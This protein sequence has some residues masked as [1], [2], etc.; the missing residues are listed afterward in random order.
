[1]NAQS[2]DLDA[3]CERLGRHRQRATYAAVADLLGLDR[4]SM[5]IGKPFTPRNS[6]VV[7]KGNGMPSKY[8]ESQVHPELFSN[9]FVISTTVDLREWLGGHP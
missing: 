1:M 6:W 9:P 8:E 7:A 4:Q 3:I 2:L 5:F